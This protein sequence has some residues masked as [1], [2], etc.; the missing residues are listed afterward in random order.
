VSRARWVVAAIAA[1]AVAPLAG[2]GWRSGGARAAAPEARRAL[3]DVSVVAQRR[4]TAPDAIREL[5]DPLPSD[6]TADVRA[7][8]TANARASTWRVTVRRPG[9]LVALRT[10]GV[11]AAGEDWV[12]VRIEGEASGASEFEPMTWE[13]TDP[14][15]L[16]TTRGL[17]RL[18]PEGSALTARLSLAAPAPVVRHEAERRHVCEAHGDGSGGFTVLCKI[19][20]EGRRVGVANVTDPRPLEDVWTMAPQ[21][22]KKTGRRGSTVVRLD[23]PLGPGAARARVL[24]YVDGMTGVVVR[25]EASWLHG[26][27]EPSLTVLTTARAQPAAP[28][29]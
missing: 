22:P 14:K 12:A 4:A 20:G 19:D 26:E 13:T 9:Q 28:R 18:A 5:A 10:A 2:A 15:T 1:A 27:P 6:I 24:G 17:L 21:A 7:D 3:A 25:A 8:E 29:F 16:A 11:R 23:L